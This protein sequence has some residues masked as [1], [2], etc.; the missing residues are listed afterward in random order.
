MDMNIGPI[1]NISPVEG[2]ASSISEGLV[3]REM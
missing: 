1:L 3:S 2:E